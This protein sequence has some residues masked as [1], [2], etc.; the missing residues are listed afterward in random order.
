MTLRR[1]ILALAALPLLALS[2]SGCLIYTD[3]IKLKKDGSG[4]ITID[5][6][7]SKKLYSQYESA[8]KMKKTAPGM[9]VPQVTLPLSFDQEELKTQL[10]HKEVKIKA[11]SVTPGARQSVHV[12][13][14]FKTLAHLSELAFPP[15][16]NSKFTF[17]AD[18]ETETY[19]YTR[20]GAVEPPQD[21]LSALN[22]L[23]SNP[24]GAD[25]A[26]Q[27]EAGLG[28][29]KE[30]VITNK[31]EMPEN[32][33]KCN[34]AD[35]KE[36]KKAMSGRTVTWTQKKPY[37]ETKI[38]LEASAETKPKKAAP[39]KKEEPKKE[40]PKKEEPKKEEPKK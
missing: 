28:E 25:P 17:N 30:A 32:V 35:E 40:E 4:T 23:K 31:V 1:T 19:T 20:V 5:Y 9:P 36:K 38:A 14:E 15:L 6:S 11:L 22:Q 7:M 2:V 33:E 3:F 13:L 10:T 8:E 12:E 26:K 34:I 18:A 21:F 39:A 29:E 37:T 24:M 27:M 16:K